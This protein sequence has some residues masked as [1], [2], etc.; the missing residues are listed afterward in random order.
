MNTPKLPFWLLHALCEILTSQCLKRISLEDLE[1]VKPSTNLRFARDA[2]DQMVEYVKGRDKASGE[3]EKGDGVRDKKINIDIGGNTHTLDDHDAAMLTGKLLKLLISKAHDKHYQDK[4]H[5]VLRQVGKEI[6]V[7]LAQF[8]DPEKIGPTAEHRS[9]N[10]GIHIIEV[11]G[12]DI[13][14]ALE[15]FLNSIK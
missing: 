6:D 10:I 11:K 7:D 2:Y 8:L 4:P 5:N 9:P 1:K 3:T 13:G 15:D 14:K 12:G